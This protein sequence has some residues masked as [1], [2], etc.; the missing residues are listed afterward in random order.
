[1][2]L[3]LKLPT[4]QVR[5]KLPPPLRPSQTCRTVEGLQK[6]PESSSSSSWLQLVRDTFVEEVRFD[7]VT[8]K[9]SGA[10]KLKPEIIGSDKI[11]WLGFIGVCS[12][13]YDSF[14]SHFFLSCLGSR[15]RQRQPHVWIDIQFSKE[16]QTKNL[17]ALWR[18]GSSKTDFS[19]LCQETTMGS[20][21]IWAHLGP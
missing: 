17:L 14:F 2:P 10:S 13:I 3:L 9:F 18:V 16:T 21:L 15:C 20:D 19:L 5:L 11:S 4:G 8:F 12:K 7:L 6:Y 1:M